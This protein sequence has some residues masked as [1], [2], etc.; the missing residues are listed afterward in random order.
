MWGI[1][2][3]LEIFL[4]IQFAYAVVT[5]TQLYEMVNSLIDLYM[6]ESCVVIISNGGYMAG[7]SVAAVYVNPYHQETQTLH[8]ASFTSEESYKKLILAPVLELG[9]TGLV[10][11]KNTD[12]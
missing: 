4:G 7:N 6:K 3:L 9:C 10:S 2:L 5:P 8:N 12:E 11:N 1:G